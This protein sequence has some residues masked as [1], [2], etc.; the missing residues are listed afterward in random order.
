LAIWG[1]FMSLFEIRGRFRADIIGNVWRSFT[2]ALESQNEKNAVEK[3][4]SLMGSEHGIKRSLIRI[5][6]VKRVE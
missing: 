5:D 1:D 3:A 6:E 2:K 4:Y